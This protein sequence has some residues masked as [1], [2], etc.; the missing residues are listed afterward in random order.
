[1]T[2]NEFLMIQ[3][4]KIINYRMNRMKKKIDDE[5]YLFIY[6]FLLTTPIKN[7]L[8]ASPNACAISNW[9]PSAVE[10]LV[11]ITTYY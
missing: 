10:R 4:S 6:F 9:K 5:F 3:I 11:G 8:P 2:V 7:G 1:M